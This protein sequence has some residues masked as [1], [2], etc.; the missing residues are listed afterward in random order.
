MQYVPLQKCPSTHGSNFVY[1]Q[2]RLLFILIALLG[3]EHAHRDTI[4][5]TLSSLCDTTA[6]FVLI[7]LQDTD[8]LESL[9]GLAVNRSRC[10]NVVHWLGTT[11]L[12][13]AVHLPQAADTDCLNDC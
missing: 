4:Q 3:L 2:A 11:V 9:H 7:L 6:T 5:I 1:R 8:L 13:A 10:V 12:G